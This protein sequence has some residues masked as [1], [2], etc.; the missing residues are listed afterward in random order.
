MVR[1]C[2][3]LFVRIV[4]INNTGMRCVMAIQYLFTNQWNREIGPLRASE[5]FEGTEFVVE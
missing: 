4:A 5:G 1:K 3:R 2:K